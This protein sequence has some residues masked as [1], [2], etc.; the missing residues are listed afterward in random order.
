MAVS[1]AVVVVYFAVKYRHGC[2]YS[3][4]T[5]WFS[6]YQTKKRQ[7]ITPY[8]APPTTTVM[9]GLCHGERVFVHA[10]FAVQYGGLRIYG[11]QGNRT[12][13]STGGDGMPQE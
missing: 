13:G 3:V 4:R 10:Y 7:H 2:P 9:S 5:P 11:G 1:V 6:D 8:E 12:G